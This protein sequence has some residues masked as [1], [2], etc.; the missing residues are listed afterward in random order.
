ML[1]NR[2]NNTTISI[3]VQKITALVYDKENK[4][5]SEKEYSLYNEKTP[6]EE[7]LKKEIKEQY[8]DTVIDI[9]SV[10]LDNEKSGTYKLS[11]R[12]FAE[13]AVKVGDVRG[14]A[15]KKEKEQWYY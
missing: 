3:Y 10:E 2:D 7:I 5:V 1:F 8:N 14:H 13:Y 9:L 6:S 4:G 11:H 12:L 15:N